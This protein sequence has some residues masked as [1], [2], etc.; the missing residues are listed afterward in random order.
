MERLWYAALSKGA[1]WSD[2]VY[3]AFTMMMFPA[4]LLL[5]Q[6]IPCTWVLVGVEKQ[7]SS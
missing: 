5:S 7:V 3:I 6:Y 4:G 1:F 2:R